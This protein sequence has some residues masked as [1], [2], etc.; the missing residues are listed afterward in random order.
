MGLWDFLFGEKKQIPP[1]KSYRD[2][3]DK[4]FSA[5][6][7]VIKEAFDQ[8]T[9]SIDISEVTRE[10]LYRAFRTAH[11][12]GDTRKEERAVINCLSKSGWKWEDYDLWSER[13]KKEQTWPSMWQYYLLVEE[14]DVMPA[15]LDE[16][17][18]CMSIPEMKEY[19]KSRGIIS[20]PAPQKK[21]EFINI[22]KLHCNIDDILPLIAEC[23][24]E[25]KDEYP[26]GMEEGKCKLLVHTLTMRIHALTNYYQI[27]DLMNCVG[28]YSIKIDSIDGC[29]TEKEYAKLYNEGH[30]KALPP[31]FPG[32]R[33]GVTSKKL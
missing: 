13:F 7:W 3:V 21:S 1:Q 9:E 15:N 2:P 24:E 22:M 11:K 17:L 4:D 25:E 23:L 31:Y 29:Q 6:E 14:E 33:N 20:K 27:I 18:G 19:L 12:S 30:T 28:G 8:I 26:A 32:D 5:A 10:N 16:A